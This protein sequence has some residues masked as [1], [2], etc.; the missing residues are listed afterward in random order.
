MLYSASMEGL[1]HLAGSFFSIATGVNSDGSVVVG[2]SNGFE[3]FRWTQAGGM[4]GLGDLAGGSFSSTAYGVNSDG[5][6]VVGHSASTNGGEAFRWTQEGG[7]VG[8]GDLAGGSF[9]SLA[10]GVNSDGSVVVGYSNS[11][12]GYE[13]FRWTQAGGM[14]GLGDLAGGSFDGWASAVNSDGSVVV[15]YSSSANG[16]EAFRWTQ[17]GG[18]VGL[19]DLAGGSFDSEANGVNS[20]GSVVVGYSSSANGGEAFRWTQEG[21]MVGL[22]DLAGGSFFSTAN[23]VNSDG[24]VVVGYS[25]SANGYEAFRWTQSTG[26]QSLTE[27]LAED[28][29]TLTGWSNTN[30][31]AVSDD[32]KTIVGFGNSTNGTEAF[33]AKAGQGMIGMSDFTAS[34][35]SINTVSSQGV[36]NA[37]MLLHGAHGHPGQRRALDERRVM[38][39]A[40][41]VSTD[42]R[43]NTR[44]DNQ[45]AEIGVSFKHSKNLT[46]SIAIGQL[47]GNSDLNY[48]GN[49]DTDGYFIAVDSDI[50]LPTVMPLYTTFT[51]IYGENDLRIKRG[52][53]N[54]G[55]LDSSIGNTNQNIMALKA[56]LQYQGEKF[57]PYIQYNMTKVITDGYSESGGGFPAIYNQ[58]SERVQDW[59]VGVDSNFKLNTTNTIITTLEATHRI[60]SRGSGVSGQLVGLSSFEI[61]GREYDQD[62]L[63]GTV[64]IEHTFK[65]KSKFTLTLNT[66][67]EGEDPRFWSGFNYSMSF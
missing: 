52:Y 58:N 30:P 15:G 62:W 23:G 19:G 11:A 12:N 24:S 2:Y 63:R 29:Y 51:G 3:A 34:L 8:L 31:N 64:G 32:G 59:R 16:G 66:T 4:V 65:N 53:D 55:N 9:F 38:W 27:W 36:A 18:M 42:N 25:N 1:G 5:S 46:Y 20:D 33:I 21:G 28:G 44:D 54:A 39:V 35:E 6:V 50:K 14:V 41:D 47:W 22:G 56:K 37:S 7:M 26:M 13:A 60:N 57:Y 61:A 10:N 67:T 17:E 45:L 49:M 40:G 43:H 48:K